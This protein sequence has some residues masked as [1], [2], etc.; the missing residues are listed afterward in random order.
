VSLE[1][2]DTQQ[3]YDAIVAALADLPGVEQ[4]LKKGFAQFGLKVDG[5]LFAS[6]MRKGDLILKMPKDRVDWLSDSGDGKRFD[7]GHGKGMKEWVV[8]SPDSAVD[9]LEL[10]REALAFVRT[11]EKK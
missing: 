3:R 4:S 8:V 2:S 10:T 5:K 1:V 9:W 7:I 11:I 6:L